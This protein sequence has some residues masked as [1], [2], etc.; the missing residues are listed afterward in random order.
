MNLDLMKSLDPA[1]NLQEMQSEEE[2]AELHHEYATIK[3]QTGKFY[4]PG[5]KR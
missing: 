4:R 1:T 5:C 2:Y 3:I